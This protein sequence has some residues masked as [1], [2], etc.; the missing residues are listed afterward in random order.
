MMR[1]LCRHNI[2]IYALAYTLAD[3]GGNHKGSRDW[4]IGEWHGNRLFAFVCLRNIRVPI[5]G[6]M[7]VPMV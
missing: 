7:E 6:L 5:C 2:H 3:L 1:A 4:W